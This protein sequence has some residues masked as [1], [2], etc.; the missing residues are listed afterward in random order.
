ME[1]KDIRQIQSDLED[2]TYDIR[3]MK[4]P[5]IEKD[6]KK[7]QATCKKRADQILGSIPADRQ[8][9][10]SE[11]MQSISTQLDELATLVMTKNPEEVIPLQRGI[12]REVGNIEQMMIATFPYEIP[13]EYK[14]LPQLKGRAVVEMKV[15]KAED[16]QFDIDGTLYD[17]GK[18]TMVRCTNGKKPKK[19]DVVSLSLFPLTMP[20]MQH[21]LLHS[22]RTFSGRSSMDT[23]RQSLRATL[24]TL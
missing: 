1:N 4:W 14:D 6:V 9:E 18:M 13:A 19:Q 23:P 21:L 11:M 2:I 3:A 15:K 12:L 16:E 8:E 7:A 5:S 22:P 17:S 24:S 10:A 20:G